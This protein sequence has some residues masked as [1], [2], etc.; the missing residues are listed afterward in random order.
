MD[1]RTVLVITVLDS[2]DNT[3]P[4]FVSQT[5]DG[6][7][8]VGRPVGDSENNAFNAIFDGNGYVIRKSGNQKRAS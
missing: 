2:G 1:S 8:V 5:A 4:Y 3:A 6:Q 7:L